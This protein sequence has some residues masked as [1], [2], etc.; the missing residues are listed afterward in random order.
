M[1]YIDIKQDDLLK[2]RDGLEILERIWDEDQSSNIYLFGITNR[3]VI[4]D[5]VREAVA[6]YMDE[7]DVTEDQIQIPE[8]AV[9]IPCSGSNV[10]ALTGSGVQLGAEEEFA[11]KG[12]QGEGI[13]TQSFNWSHVKAVV[14]ISDF[15]KIALANDNVWLDNY[16]TQRG[17]NAIATIQKQ[18]QRNTP[19][20]ATPQ[21]TG[22][23]TPPTIEGNPT[24]KQTSLNMG[25]VLENWLG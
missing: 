23:T 10:Y 19:A 16:L 7:D 20:A 13:R 2:L 6:N 5:A 12:P 18:V 9:S 8:V 21:L 11:Y 25:S 4:L 17:S 3:P 14:T 1:K 24:P 22:P 15:S